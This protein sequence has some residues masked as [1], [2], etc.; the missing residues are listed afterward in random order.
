MLWEIIDKY[1]SFYFIGIGG[2]SMS[3][4]AKYL[5]TLGKYVGG[6]DVSKNEYTDELIKNGVKIDFGNFSDNIENYEFVIYTDAI[7]EEDFRLR[8]ARSLSKPTV[9][10]GEF[11]Q[12][13]SQNFKSVIAV[14]G[15]HG[16]TTCCAMLTH[17]FVAAGKKFTSHIGGKDLVF[18]N[19]YC[20]GNNFFIT[21]ACEYKK[22]FLHLKPDIA[23]ILNSDADHIECYGSEEALKSAYIEFSES[24]KETIL[25]Y[26]DL[27]Q[28]SGLSFGFDKLSDYFASKIRDDGGLC[29][30]ALNE[31][32]QEL[33]DITLNVYGKHNIL[34]A[35]AATA[36]A[37][38]FGISFEQ[39]REG[40]NGFIGVERRFEKLAEIQG[41]LYYADYAH[42]PN[43]LRAALKTVRKIASGRLFII[44]QPHTYSRT[45]LLF[46]DFINVLSP[47]SNLL[48]YKTFAAREYYDDAGSALTLSQSLK[49]A[50]YGDCPEDIKN[51]ISKAVAG[52]IV[53]FLGAGDIYFIAKEICSQLKLY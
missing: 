33:G 39:I 19:F 31:K 27:P 36:V 48:I 24:A 6:S 2:V 50:S 29:T 22:N 34:N 8:K 11:L 26:K 49:R 5:L 20:N 25:L 10:R 30:F 52:D 28:I 16:K 41:A 18:S 13:I 12:A 23:V 4:L 47:L 42:H 35:L 15:C 51:F 43:E 45:K 32:G 3:G 1:H 21:E 37:R 38:C 46:S 14:S 40:L 9:S 17:I 7:H 44:F 53:L